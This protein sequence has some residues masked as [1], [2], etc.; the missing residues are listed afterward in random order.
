VDEDGEHQ[1]PK[2]G[3]LTSN[4]RKILLN[5]ETCKNCTPQGEK[6]LAVMEYSQKT[7]GELVI[8]PNLATFK[9]LKKP[10]NKRR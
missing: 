6:L 5:V 2:C 3:K 9:E 4:L 8:C 10:A 1:C 7:G